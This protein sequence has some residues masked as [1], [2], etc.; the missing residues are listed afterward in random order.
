V[1]GARRTLHDVHRRRRRRGLGAVAGAH[2]RGRAVVLQTDVRFLPHYGSLLPF[3]GHRVVLAGYEDD[4]AALVA[5]T[6]FE[7]L[8]RVPADALRAARGSDGPPMGWSAN[9]W[10]EIEAPARLPE[11]GEAARAAMRR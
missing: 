8:V 4:G 7:G 1:R 5:D 10:W 11:L 9:L 3:N 6:H 2:R